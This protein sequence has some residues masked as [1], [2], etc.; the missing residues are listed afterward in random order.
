MIREFSGLSEFS[1]ERAR[2]LPLQRIWNRGEEARF[3]ECILK[4]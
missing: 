3:D 4:E 2:L 1:I